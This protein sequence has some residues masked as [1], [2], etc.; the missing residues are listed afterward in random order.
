MTNLAFA[1]PCTA[2][3][4]LRLARA[5]FVDVACMA[6]TGPIAFSAAVG[7]VRRSLEGG[8]PRDPRP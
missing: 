5:W 6:V 7:G 8:P 4:E 3:P 2:A 1:Q